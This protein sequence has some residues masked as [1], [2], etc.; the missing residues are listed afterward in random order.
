MKWNFAYLILE[1]MI[2]I[3]I[4]HLNIALDRHQIGKYV[5][6]SILATF[7]ISST[8]YT[9]RCWQLSF[10]SGDAP[11]YSNHRRELPA[12]SLEVLVVMVVQGCPERIRGRLI[13][14]SL[15]GGA[16]GLV[17]RFIAQEGVEMCNWREVQI[18]YKLQKT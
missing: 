17:A 14:A 4:S 9:F 18:R 1:L 2:L 5:E 3:F 12:S 11:T 8:R 6:H 16:A 15:A 7:H 13:S 10:S